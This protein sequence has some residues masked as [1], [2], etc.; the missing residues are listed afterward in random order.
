LHCGANLK[1]IISCRVV[2]IEYV[3][4]RRCRGGCQQIVFHSFGPAV[5][6]DGRIA[7]RRGEFGSGTYYGP[8]QRV[9]A[10]LLFFFSLAAVFFA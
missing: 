4:D 5:V 8:W 7:A 9:L 3:F 2:V 1:T 6:P 10:I